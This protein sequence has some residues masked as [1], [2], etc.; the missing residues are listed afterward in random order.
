M[1]EVLAVVGGILLLLAVTGGIQGIAT[2]LFEKDEFVPL[3]DRIAATLLGGALI[4]LAAV[5]DAGVKHTGLWITLGVGAAIVLGLAGFLWLEFRRDRKDD[6][7]VQVLRE[8]LDAFNRHDL[9][10][11]MSRFAED[12]VFESPRGSDVWGQRF[13]GKQ[14]V[15]SGLAARFEGIPDV[16]CGGDEH[17]ASGNR[18]ASEWTLTGTTVAGERIAVRGCDLWTFGKDGKLVRKT[19]FWKIHES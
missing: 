12:C 2:K 19:S 5:L 6:R 4:G 17:F 18:G 13:L 7:E 1:E 16:H 8:V 9:D 14:A 15:R 3:G 11:I 10:A